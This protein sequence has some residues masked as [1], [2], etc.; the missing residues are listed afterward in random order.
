MNFKYLSSDFLHEYNGLMK[1]YREEQLDLD[2]R[3]SGRISE[4][5]EIERARLKENIKP[6]FKVGQKVR[7]ISSGKVGEI[8]EVYLDFTTDRNS[9]ENEN[10]TGPGRYLPI[11]NEKD[12]A[13][14]TC[15][16]DLIRYKIKID[17]DLISKDYGIDYK[18]I[19]AWSDEV[20][21]I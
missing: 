18:I 17:S 7:S 11:E 8:T 19:E 9:F 20:E 5:L 1:Q 6:E 14:A 21:R 4:L 10:F 13:V 3:F 12:E 16:G 15:E 2:S